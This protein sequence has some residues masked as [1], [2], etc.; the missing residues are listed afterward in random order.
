ME[1]QKTNKNDIDDLLDITR[2]RENKINLA[3]SHVN[4]RS[5]VLGVLDMLHILSEHKNIEISVLIPEHFPSLMVDKKRL[6]QILYNILHNTIK[7]TEKGEIT[8][9]AHI[10]NKKAIVNIND[11]GIGMDEETISR[12]FEPYEQGEHSYSNSEGIGLGLFICKQ[13]IELH[14]GTLEVESEIGIGSSFSFSLPLVKETM[15]YQVDESDRNDEF[16]LEALLQISA[17]TL[18]SYVNKK[19]DM[20]LNYRP[21]ILVVDDDIVNLNALSNILSNEQ[22]DVVTVTSGREALNKLHV[23]EWD[24]IITDVMMPYMTGYE[25]T[26]KIRE[27]FALWELPIILLT[28]RSDL[29]DIYT[30][31]TAGANDYVVKPANS[32]ELKIRVNTM[33]NFKKSLTDHLYMESAF[34]QAQIKPHF[35]YNTLNTIIS[36]F[37]IDTSSE[38][39]IELLEQFGNYLHKSFDIKNLERVVPLN[40]E[41]DLVRSYLYIEKV[42]YGDHLQIE[43]NV[44]ENIS[45]SIPPLSIQTLVE[46]AIRH[47]IMKNI[48]GGK[49]SI[50]IKQKNQ[51]VKISI[52]DN[53]VGMNKE[54]IQKLLFNEIN[55]EK[56]IGIRN[57]QKRLK[58]LYGEG[59]IFHSQLGKGT[60]VSFRIPKPKAIE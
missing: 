16:S 60:K 23:K 35:L 5:T 37:R 6:I 11:T 55:K 20:S 34:L 41:L 54:Q 52:V 36:L 43:W 28:A 38:R 8:V 10:E 25:L 1:K 29:E 24:L 49:I 21:K 45:L 42:R 19:Q 57:T 9:R 50:I 17:T 46:N 47:G 51:F 31:F 40:H 22:Y 13:L 56:G 15:M 53:G 39:A 44:D 58:Q 33:C 30:G 7:F 27:K 14:G 48:T 26:K 3:T 12:I 18:G 32:L 59:L 2:L 4:L